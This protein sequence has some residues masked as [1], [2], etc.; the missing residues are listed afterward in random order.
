[1][2]SIRHY[3]PWII[4]SI[5]FGVEITLHGKKKGC[6]DTTL[7]MTLSSRVKAGYLILEMSA[8]FP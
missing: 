5:H 7:K 1:M 6:S 4:K 2:L 3:I 8:F